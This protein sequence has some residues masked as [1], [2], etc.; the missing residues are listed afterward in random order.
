M[1]NSYK[2]TLTYVYVII[3]IFTSKTS[4]A[5]AARSDN[6]YDRAQSL[7]RACMVEETDADALLFWSGVTRYMV[8]LFG[9][10]RTHPK[11]SAVQR[12]H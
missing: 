7:R 6:W 2:I 1:K 8:E 3:V 5:R 10:L 12:G 11:S 4:K 9:G